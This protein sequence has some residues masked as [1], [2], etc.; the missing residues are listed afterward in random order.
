MFYCFIRFFSYKHILPCDTVSLILFFLIF[1]MITLFPD[2]VKGYN[3]SSISEIFIHSEK[4]GIRENFLPVLIYQQPY[5]MDALR[6][7][8]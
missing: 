2:V 3:I 1:I 7:H 5:F 8:I 6:N 4:A